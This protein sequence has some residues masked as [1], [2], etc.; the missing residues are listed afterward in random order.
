M[1]LFR[2]LLGLMLI[3]LILSGCAQT[4][5]VEAPIS[6]EPTA[7]ATTAPTPT[8]EPLELDIIAPTP[9][10]TMTPAPSPTPNWV[11]P[12]TEKFYENLS[13]NLSEYDDVIS[14][15]NLSKYATVVENATA[16]KQLSDDIN[17]SVLSAIDSAKECAVG[18]ID[19][20]TIEFDEFSWKEIAAL[21]RGLGANAKDALERNI[22]VFVSDDG[23]Y[24]VSYSDFDEIIK[25]APELELLTAKFSYAYLNTL[26]DEDGV[27]KEY[28]S[29]P[30]T[31]EYLATLANPVPGYHMKDGW[32][33]SR[34]Q[35]TRRHTGMDI[36]GRYKTPLLATTDG[37]VV[38]M[39]E[40]ETCGYYIVIEDAFGFEY[41]YYHLAEPS[42]LHVGDE[43]KQNDVVGLMGKTGNATAIHLH[44][45]IISPD[46]TY[47]NPYEVYQMAGLTD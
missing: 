41:H 25:Y 42:E 7:L 16:F 23:C 26:Y 29:Y 27:Q 2:Y 34:S 8:I 46:Y 30:L 44:I 20:V 4:K 32:Y 19:E 12:S 33:D 10:P 45:A 43:V 9:N 47:I 24:S 17:A 6:P 18:L 39:G 31:D 15:L 40:H 28:T 37:I 3:T 21:I 36:S 38:Y 35:G 1:K 11:S 14:K 13:L 22:F 5:T